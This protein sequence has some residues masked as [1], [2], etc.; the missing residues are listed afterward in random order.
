MSWAVS[1]APRMRTV[2]PESLEELR[3]GE[4]GRN[5]DCEPGVFL[6]VEECRVRKVWCLLFDLRSEVEDL[7]VVG[8]TRPLM[9]VEK[10]GVRFRPEQTI[11]ASHWCSLE[12]IV[13]RSSVVTTCPPP[14]RRRTLVT[15]ALQ[16]M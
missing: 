7:E 1:P 10:L 12:T 16:R 9:S 14:R 15:R 11:T 4:R 2:E 6:K 3:E 13:P 5:S 8:V